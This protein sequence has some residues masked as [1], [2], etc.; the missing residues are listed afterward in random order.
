MSTPRRGASDE[1]PQHCFRREI[2]KILRGYPLL[3]VAMLLCHKLLVHITYV[4][5]F[6]LLIITASHAGR[7][8]WVDARAGTITGYGPVHKMG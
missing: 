4:T 2:R 7:Y 1:Y 3:S 6:F 5:S 8:L